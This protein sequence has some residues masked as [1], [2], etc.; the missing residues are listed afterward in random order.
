MT[1]WLPHP[2]LSIAV[3]LLWLALLQSVAPVD[4]ASAVVL[5]VVVPW[6]CAPVLPV[7]PRVRRW[8]RALSYLLLVA[9]DIVVANL[10]VARLVLS[11]LS[12]LA[13]R[14]V[15]VPLAT[16]DPV[17]ASLLAATVTLTP[18]TVSIDLDLEAGVLVVHAL[19]AGDPDALVAEIKS[20]YEAR[21]MEVFGC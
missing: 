10:A 18:G 1:R 8:D 4:V 13:P 6:W 11:P 3:A 15:Q 7:V 21:L 17:V 12:R 16:R 20:R 5:G 2:R 19:A 14:I 9:R